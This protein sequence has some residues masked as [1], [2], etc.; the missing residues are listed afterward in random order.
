MAT[1]TFLHLPTPIGVL[2]LVA[3]DNGLQRIDFPPPRPPPAGQDWT[4]GSTEARPGIADH[5]VGR[6]LQ[7]LRAAV[8]QQH[9]Q[10]ALLHLG[11]GH[12]IYRFVAPQ[13]IEEEDT[14]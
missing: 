3:G 8:V 11:R 4:E 9:R 14:E 1:T 5:A 2:T 6:V 7:R 12:G 13:V 10:Q